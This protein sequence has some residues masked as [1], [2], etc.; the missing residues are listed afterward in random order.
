MFYGADITQDKAEEIAAAIAEKYPDQEIE[1][2][3]G[4]QPHYQF[5]F[6]VE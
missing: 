3:K 2:Q 1:I 5:I 4:G 6:S